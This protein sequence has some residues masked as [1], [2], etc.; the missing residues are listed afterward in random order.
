M[1][2]SQLCGAGVSRAGEEGELGALSKKLHGG[3]GQG[4]IG[5]MALDFPDVLMG[6]LVADAVA[7]PVH[8][9]YDT[10]ALRRDYG[11]VDQFLAPRSPHADSILWRS[12]YE[13]INERGDILREQA[14]F[15]GQ[16]GVH[17][18]QFLAAGENTLNFKLA[19]EL[20]GMVREAG[21]YDP[22]AWLER[23]IEFMLTPGRH[24]DTY[25]EEY[26]RAFF[27][28]LA[29]GKKPRACGIEDVHIGGL[30]QVPALIAALGAGNPELVG[31]VKTH[32][33]LTHGKTGVVAAAVCLVRIHAGLAAGV[34]LRDA[35]LEN[36]SE[37]VSA[38]KTEKWSGLE[39]EVVVGRMLSPACYIQD[40]FPAALWLAWKYAG[41]F[42]AGIL[43]NANVG[44]DNCHRG[45]VVGSLLGAANG[46]PVRWRDGLAG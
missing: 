45:A 35:I 10:A 33:G 43:A 21:K 6:A 27:T 18:H 42:S 40:A 46:V 13:P 17:Y 15:W 41:D 22:G 23:Y 31:V 25:V 9:Y 11:V 1:G 3:A 2:N 16:R 29:R 24:R 20:F 28:N 8:W 14:R 37:Y 30:A 4:R 38:R 39:D 36:A 26:H 7:M 19:V 44:G 32:V 34:P 12:R 5:D